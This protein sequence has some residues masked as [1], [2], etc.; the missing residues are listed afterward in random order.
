MQYRYFRAEREKEQGNSAFKR[1]DYEEAIER[2]KVAYDIEPEMPHYQLNLAAAYLKINKWI[3]AE[4]A[5]DLALRQHKSVKGHWRRAQARKSQGKPDDAI[6]DLRAVLRLQPN[7]EE[8]QAELLSLLPP[9]PGRKSQVHK[10]KNLP[11]F[12]NIASSSAMAS[13]SSSSSQQY[14]P[15]SSSYTPSGGGSSSSNFKPLP[16]T[17]TEADSRRLQITLLPMT[18]KLPASRSVSVN[19]D[20][21]DG[22]Q[23]KTHTI[24]TT[25]SPGNGSTKG[26]ETYIYPCWE[27][28]LIRKLSD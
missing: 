27:R 8:A 17:K 13:G 22:K 15:S 26:S 4:R 20:T 16:F 5:C 2:Y 23:V 1:G 9:D 7:N 14:G 19:T 28:Y 24:R 18:F 21:R 25:F 12:P 11:A 3:E 10:T 6:K